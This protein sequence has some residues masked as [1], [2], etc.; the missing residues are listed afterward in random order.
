MVRRACLAIGVSTVTPPPN[1]ALSFAYLDGAV[2]AA[3]SIGEWAL[4][5]GFGE[6][7]VRVVDD[8]SVGGAANPVTRERVQQAVDELFAPG[9]DVVAHLILAFCGHGLT[10]SNVSSIS[11]LFSDSLRL[12]YRVLSDLFYTELVLHGVK[13][14]T[15]IT[16]A[17]REAPKNLDLMRLDAV[18]GI[19]VN[20]TQIDSPRFDRLAGCQDGQLGYMVSDPTSAVP[21]KCVF[22]GVILDILWGLEPDAILD[23]V[24]TTATLGKFVRSRTSERASEYRLTLNPQCLVD[25]DPIVLYDW[26]HPLP[27]APVLQPWPAASAVSV[28]GA[29][30]H[31]ELGE[32]GFKFRRWIL[33]KIRVRGG[34]EPDVNRIERIERCHVL[35]LDA[36]LIL[37]NRLVA[38][39]AVFG[40]GATLQTHARVLKQGAVADKRQVDVTETKNVLN[41]VSDPGDANI[42]VWSR[43]ACALAP[44]PI[45]GRERQGEFLSLSVST[46][47]QG[48]PILVELS[49]GSFSPVVPYE[50]YFTVVAESQS[51]EVFQAYGEQ[52]SLR[53]YLEAVA[54]IDDFAS[55]RL[56]AESIRRITYL[57][58]LEKNADPMLSIICAYLFRAMADYD[59]IRR[60]AFFYAQLGQPVPFDI[61]LLGAMRVTK[62]GDGALYVHVP[63]VRARNEG[64]QSRRLPPYLTRETP[65]TTAP[66]G[67][68][69]PWLGLGWDYVLDPR[70]EW[71]VLVEGLQ[72]HA[73]KVPRRGATVLPGLVARE[74][75]EDWKLRV[76]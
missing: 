19:I 46:N 57:I 23:G 42:L 73:D 36:D 3:R 45:K 50:R 43:K 10:D 34:S 35:K 75:A 33:G 26:A 18:R 38:A 27:V 76:S 74:L 24:L 28:L 17:C 66:I 72:P 15:L 8:G 13:H 59:S 47:R 29:P 7:N 32:I 21:G 65:A 6:S 53:Q 61:A 48:M 41:L 60:M 70:E 62:S 68:R 1:M 25:P 55:G 56:G 9:T 69:C 2:L 58:R 67:G 37:L 12:K 51:G 40:N 71:I 31:L 22:S 20:G 44:E 11:W 54:V 64:P 49:N 14:I 30:R 16:D 4:S 63:A 39:E 5:A 52:S